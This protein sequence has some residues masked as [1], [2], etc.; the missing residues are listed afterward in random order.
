MKKQIRRNYSLTRWL[1]AGVLILG[2]FYLPS[3]IA[4]TGPPLATKDDVWKVFYMV[5]VKGDFIV[6]PELGS[7]GPVVKYHID[8]QYKGESEMVFL[9]IVKETQS[10]RQKPQFKGKSKNLDVKIDDSIKSST[11]P[12][13]TSYTTSEENWKADFI[14]YETDYPTLLLINNETLTYKTSFPILANPD[15]KVMG[16]QIEYH[17]LELTITGPEKLENSR[18][19]KKETFNLHEYPNVPGFIER[20]S[21]IRSPSWSELKKIDGL[22]GFNWTSTEDLH[23]DKP[24]FPNV[25]ESR[26]QVNIVISY[27]FYKK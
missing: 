4:Q 12:E 17:K 13:C 18:I 19:D 24:I 6:E 15:E 23:P 26:D 14:V 27:T 21:I 9:P 10:S 8:R 5:T 16:S 7:G 20:N 3:V 22:N 11:D 2:F 1:T 25:P